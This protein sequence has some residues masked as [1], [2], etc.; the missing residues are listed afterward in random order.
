MIAY[1]L[2]DILRLVP[3]S[4]DFVKKANLELDFPLGSKEDAI[5]SSLAVTYLTQ[6][7]P[8]YTKIDR[9]TI[10]KVASAVGLFNVSTQAAEFNDKLVKRAS[11]ERAERDRIEGRKS[12]CLVK[13]AMFETSLSGNYDPG[14]MASLAESLVKEAAELNLDVNETVR[15]YAGEYSLD[16]QAAI[17]SLNSRYHATKN[18]DFA[19]IATAISGMPDEGY[20]SE[21]VQDICKTISHMDKEANLQVMGFDFYKEAL[22]TKSAASTCLPIKLAGTTVPYESIQRLG[23][24]NLSRYIGED[25]AKEFDKG[26]QDTKIALETLPLDLQRVIL[27]LAK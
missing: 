10:E 23:R 12:N 13:Q 8:D 3:E 6:V 17:R 18:A 20:K 11:E 9:H 25:V 2:K 16:K 5:A 26:P 7:S 21:T 14:S 15:R 1:H 24:D 4:T 19:K 27:K 22:I